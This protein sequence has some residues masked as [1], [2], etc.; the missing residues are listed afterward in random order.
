MDEYI[1]FPID[2]KDAVEFL[3][4]LVEHLKQTGKPLQVNTSRGIVDL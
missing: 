3:G 2:N 4:G 1:D